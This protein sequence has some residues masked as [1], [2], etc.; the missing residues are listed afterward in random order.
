MKNAI[1]Q[2]INRNNPLYKFTS[3]TYHAFQSAKCLIFDRA[4]FEIGGLLR[5]IRID[6]R[7][8]RLD[9][10]KD[11]YKGQGKRAF[12]VATGPSL[13]IGDLEKL[14]DEI[15]FGVNGVFQIYG[16]TNWRPT[17]YGILDIFVYQR[18][19][20]NGIKFDFDR[21]A[22]E[23]AFVDVSMRKELEKN[24]E[25]EKKISFVPVFRFNHYVNFNSRHF[26]FSKDLRRGHFST[27]TVTNFA[28]NLA[29]Y[30]GINEIYLL[31]VDCSYTGKKQY[32]NGVVDPKAMSQDDAYHTQQKMMDS[33]IYVK[34][35]LDALGIHVY[36]ATKGGELEV[37]KRRNF[38]DLF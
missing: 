28:I 3:N 33:Y 34:K 35:Q 32:A 25:S 12:V 27:W 7:F 5:R 18:F 37:F 16:K 6:K 17:Y 31:G 22:T 19:I 14:K 38:D 21:I 11:I 8:L 24:H 13:T 29:V 20:E 26:G 23:Q 36:N 2:H 15:T 4:I 30:M 9:T 1:K 10:Y